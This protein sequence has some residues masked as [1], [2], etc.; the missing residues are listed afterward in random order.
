MSCAHVYVQSSR[1]E[2]AGVSVLEAAAA[3]V[4]TVGTSVGYVADW[5]PDAAAAVPAGDATAM[6]RQIAALLDDPAARMALGARAHA[7]SAAFTAADTAAAFDALY[8]SVA[9]TDSQ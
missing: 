3:G 9:A 7:S 8:R 2:A 6:A 4:P 5:A 1:H